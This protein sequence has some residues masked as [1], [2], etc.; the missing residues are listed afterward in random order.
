[1]GPGPAMFSSDDCL[2]DYQTISPFFPGE[3]ITIRLVSCDSTSTIYIYKGKHQIQT[4]EERMSFFEGNLGEPIRIA[5]INGDGLKDIKL[6]IPYMGNGLAAENMRIIYLFQ[7]PGMKFTKIVYMDKMPE[8]RPERDMNKDGNYEIITKTLQEHGA[9]NYWLFNI[10]NFK[11]NKLVN[12]NEKFGYP[13]MVQ[14]LNRDNY[15]PANID[16][17]ILKKYSMKVPEDYE[18]KPAK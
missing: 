16:K 9:H 3:S 14:Y 11:D 17:S 6:V 8:N 10:Y 13:I 2:S 4:I 18:V 7:R 5:D 1:M 12:V 15:T